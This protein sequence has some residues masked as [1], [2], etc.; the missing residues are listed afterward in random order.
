MKTNKPWRYWQKV[1]N[2]V[3]EAYEAM[4]REGWSSLPQAD[5]LTSRGY[6]GLVNAITTYRGGFH[7]F[8]ELLGQASTRRKFGAWKDLEYAIA[9]ACEIM[10]REGWKKLP[11]GSTLDSKGYSSLTN[12]ICKYHGGFTLFKNHLGQESRLSNGTWNADYASQQALKVMKQEGWTVL[13]S[14]HVLAKKGY[15]MLGRAII[16]FCGGFYKFR[17][18]LGQKSPRL[19]ANMWKDL[20]YAIQRAVQIMQDEGWKELP[21]AAA[22]GKKGYSSLSR[23]IMK[24]HGGYEAFRQNLY[25]SVGNPDKE[26]LESLLDIYTRR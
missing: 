21:G 11:G 26:R 20:S 12:S 9:Q 25:Q 3:S 22:L 19:P 2:C 15:S 6:S 1:E 18:H 24:Y 14:S 4:R 7:S 23:A 13:P 16:K 10:K 5:I 17:Q 8:R